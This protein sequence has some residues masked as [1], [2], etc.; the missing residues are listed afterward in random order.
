[1]SFIRAASVCCIPLERARE[2]KISFIGSLQR[3][4][5]LTLD[6]SIMSSPL[7]MVFLS[8]GSVYGRIRSL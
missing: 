1:M 4:G 6:R 2:V 5:C 3:E 7:M 8:L